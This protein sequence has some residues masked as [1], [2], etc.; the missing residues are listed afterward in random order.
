MAFNPFEQKALKVEKRFRDWKTL[1]KKAYDKE[2]VDPYTKTRII[3]MN[4]T[5]FE[6]VWFMHQFN[7]H[8]P[9]N[10]VRRELAMVRRVEQEQQK[11]IAC[12]KPLNETI[13]ETT[14]SYE[15]LAVDLTARLAAREPNGYVKKAYDFALLEDFD[16]LYRFADLLEMDDGI[17]AEKL[18]GGYT[19]IMPGRPTVAHHRCPMDD[20][21]RFVDFKKAEPLTKLGISIITAAEQ[22]TMN[23]YMNQCGFYKNDLGR[24]LFQ[25]IGMVEEQHV[26]H[27]GSLK[28]P[29]E[30]WFECWLMHE[31]TECYLYYSMMNDEKDASVK[32]L[33]ESNLND[34][35]AHLHKA[36]EMLEKYEKR[37]WNEI[38]PCPEFPEL[39]TLGENKDYV[40]KVQKTAYLTSDREDYVDVRKLNGDESFFKYQ[41]KVNKN[42][43]HTP[44]HNVIETY[45]KK[46]EK[47][48]R[49]EDSP[50]PIKELR[51]RKSDNITVGRCNKAE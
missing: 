42:C 44:S 23:Y 40:R 21:R 35:L 27:Y 12:L 24:R 38:I 39:L 49:Y 20:I 32:A 10:N 13:L 28:D 22:Q 8:C 30:T 41:Q 3:L 50:N 15:Q 2:S 7:R 29:N 4:G 1:Y 6:A 43:A 45:L 37:T 14:I 11:E 51:D 46:H 34:E 26:S 47:D 18:V 48:Y 36:A 25:E 16:H 9:D 19:E 17:H 5:E 33:W 31:Y